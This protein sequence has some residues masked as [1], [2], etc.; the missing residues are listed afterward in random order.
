MRRFCRE[1]TC[2]MWMGLYSLFWNTD[3][4]HQKFKQCVDW[5]TVCRRI[6]AKM[7]CAAGVV[8][9]PLTPMP[10]SLDTTV[11]SCCGREPTIYSLRIIPFIKTNNT[12]FNYIAL[13]GSKCVQKILHACARHSGRLK[14]PRKANIKTK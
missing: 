14:Q 2:G 5:L 1:V 3:T 10:G 9:A 8:Q 6:V 11:H 7:P 13:G 4:H 12:L